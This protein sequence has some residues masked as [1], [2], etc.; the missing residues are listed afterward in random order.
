MDGVKAYTLFAPGGI[1]GHAGI[2]PGNSVVYVDE[3]SNEILQISPIGTP[4]V[5]RS[6]EAPQSSTKAK[7]SQGEA[8]TDNTAQDAA[9][10]MMG[11]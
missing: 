11:G 3:A 4:F 8:L 7:K 5:G 1:E 2:F 10:A 6:Q 9:N